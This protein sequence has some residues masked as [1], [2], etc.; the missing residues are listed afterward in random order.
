MQSLF[1]PHEGL[2]VAKIDRLDLQTG[3]RQL[4]RD[5]AISDRVG[6]LASGVVVAPK[7]RLLL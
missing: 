7:R 3:Q 6:I 1:V 4:W 5:I 2:P